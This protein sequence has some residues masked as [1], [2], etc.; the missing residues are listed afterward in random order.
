[1]LAVAGFSVLDGRAGEGSRLNPSSALGNARHQRS[2]GLSNRL[3]R[4]NTLR[5]VVAPLGGSPDGRLRG[6]ARPGG[7]KRPH[8]HG[9]LVVAVAVV[10]SPTVAL[11][12]ALATGRLSV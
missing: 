9:A 7:R 11:V 1:M 5:L 10:G 12:A 3:V 4:V 2:S 8:L 6:V